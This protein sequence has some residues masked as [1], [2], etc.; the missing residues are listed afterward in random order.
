VEKRLVTTRYG[1]KFF[2]RPNPLGREQLK[3]SKKLDKISFFGRFQTFFSESAYPKWK[4][5]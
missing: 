5:K 1:G 3:K 2:L 4:S